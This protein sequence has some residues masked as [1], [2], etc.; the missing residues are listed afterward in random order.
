[1]A[2]IVRHIFEELVSQ[3]R[4]DLSVH[5]EKRRS[6]SNSIASLRLGEDTSC[7]TSNLKLLDAT[8]GAVNSVSLVALVVHDILE[9]EAAWNHWSVLDNCCRSTFDWF[10]HMREILTKIC[11]GL[12]G[13]CERL[14]TL[15]FSILTETF[16]AVV[17]RRVRV[18]DLLL[19]GLC[20]LDLGWKATQHPH[21]DSHTLPLTVNL[22]SK[23]AL[24]AASEFIPCTLSGVT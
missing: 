22:L 9:N 14:R 21:A 16:V 18:P 15:G 4:L 5:V 2:L 8:W 24:L 10:A 17:Q 6:A 19:L 7:L 3:R 23:L 20:L 1:M 13:N 11:S 12:T